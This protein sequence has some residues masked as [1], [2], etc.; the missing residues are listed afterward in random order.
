MDHRLNANRDYRLF[1]QELRADGITGEA[2]LWYYALKA[3]KMNGY[4]FHRR[5]PI[6]DSVVDFVCPKLS[7]IIEIN[8]SSLH[9]NP[10]TNWI[11]K[12]DFGKLGYTVLHLSESKVFD[13]L[14]KSVAR[15]RNTVEE[16]GK[17]KKLP[18]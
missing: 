3:K 12:N 8:L 5:R 11:R 17:K 9:A 16:L 18:H 6:G 7:L 14:D 10:A 2:I 4:Q 13:N 1:A 15:I